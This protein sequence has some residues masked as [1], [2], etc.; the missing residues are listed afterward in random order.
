MPRRFLKTFLS[1]LSHTLL[2]ELNFQM[3]ELDISLLKLCRSGLV[4]LQIEKSFLSWEREKEI[5]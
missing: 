4:I 3:S 2:S 5:F 1:S